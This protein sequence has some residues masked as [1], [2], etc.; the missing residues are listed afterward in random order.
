[1]GAEVVGN[2]RQNEENYGDT[3]DIPDHGARFRPAAPGRTDWRQVARKLEGHPAADD[4]I[5]IRHH[6]TSAYHE[7]RV[8]NQEF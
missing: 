7:L 2:R 8:R 5:R 1:M 4:H 6:G 3:N